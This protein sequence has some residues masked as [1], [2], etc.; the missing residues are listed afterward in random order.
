VYLQSF[1]AA[2]ATPYS[3]R[4]DITLAGFGALGDLGVHMIDAVR[5]VTGLEFD[6][7]AGIAATLIPSKR[8]A[9]GKT[10]KITT[11]TNASFLARLSNGIT[12]TF[13]T[14]QVAAGYSNYHRI[15]VSGTRGTLAV[16]SEKEHELWLYA[17]PT[18]TRYTTWG[19]SSI[20]AIR[21][22]SAFTAQQPPATPGLLADV[23]RGQQ[24]D[25][26]SFEDGVRAQRVLAAI[27]DS[28][29]SRRWEKV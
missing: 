27:L 15:E 3:W 2:E 28:N 9:A 12:G 23:L 21:V 17:G 16:L 26:P 4:N 24:R 11:D 1:L 29:R 20:P 14:N 13:E 22:P 18:F 19:G 6:R 8:D 10:R 5:F 7:V 25:Y